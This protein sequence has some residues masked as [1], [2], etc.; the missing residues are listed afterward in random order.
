MIR[1]LLMSINMPLES[2]QFNTPL[3]YF[4]SQSP[5][6]RNTFVDK[7]V[8]KSEIVF[9]PPMFESKLQH[10]SMFSMP[11]DCFANI[12]NSHVDVSTY[13]DNIVVASASNCSNGLN[14]T[15]YNSEYEQMSMS[16][17]HFESFNG[18]GN[19]QHAPAYPHSPTIER[20]H[21]PMNINH[22]QTNMENLA[23]F[24]K[25][26]YVSCSSDGQQGVSSF[27]SS[28]E[29]SCYMAQLQNMPMNERIGQFNSS[30]PV[31]YSQY[32]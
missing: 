13:G 5:L 28:T 22:D 12:V 10:A 19:I 24:H 1:L 25:A 30:Y 16:I 9:S 7:E 15:Y 29:N 18:F 23:N 31:N 14:H 26:S 6:A 32:S 8:L 20:I 3:N 27:H 21:M 4:S 11:N 17:M 2:I